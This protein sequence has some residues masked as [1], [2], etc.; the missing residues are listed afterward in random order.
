MP[1]LLYLLIEAGVGSTALLLLNSLN[2]LSIIQNIGSKISDKELNDLIYVSA[3][4][5]PPIDLTIREEFDGTNELFNISGAADTLTSNYDPEFDG[6]FKS[7]GEINKFYKFL[8]SNGYKNF[9]WLKFSNMTTTIASN[10]GVDPRD[11]RQVVAYLIRNCSGQMPAINAVQ[12]SIRAIESSYNIVIAET[13]P[14]KHVSSSSG[15]VIIV[16]LS[17]NQEEQ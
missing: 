5:N 6:V 14:G 10:A 12:A 16:M 3:F 2:Q 15:P 9:P 8:D 11:I 7:Q 17:R 4:I 13:K 1:K